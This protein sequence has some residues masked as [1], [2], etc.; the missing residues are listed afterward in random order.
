MKRVL[1]MI[2]ATSLVGGAAYAGDDDSH[3]YNGIAADRTVDTDG[4]VEMNGAAISLSGRIGGDVDMNGAAVDIEARIG[5]D[6][7][8]N[9]GAMEIDAQV[10]GRTEV[11]GGA[12]SLSGRYMGRTH[13][14]GGAIELNGEF[15][16]G[17]SANFGALEFDGLASGPVNFSGQRR[18][19]VF[20]RGDRSGVRIGGHIAAGGEICAHKVTFETGARVDSRLTVYSDEEPTYEDGFDSSSVSFVQ[21]SSASC[22]EI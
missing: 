2:A 19:G 10:N 15:P 14:N 11:N 13:I 9:G 12:V 3:S 20:R 4:D 17:V 7:D 1:L 21:R 22:R 18:N 16:R 6:L 5:G 8:A